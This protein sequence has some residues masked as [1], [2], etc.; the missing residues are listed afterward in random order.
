MK[1][2]NK[3]GVSRSRD[4]KGKIV[5]RELKDYTMCVHAQVGGCRESM[6]VLVAEVYE[7]HDTDMCNK[8]EK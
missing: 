3:Y 4:K 8:G 7:E 1:K 2:I 5:K 6:W